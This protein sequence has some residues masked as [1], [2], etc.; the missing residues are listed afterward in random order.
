MCDFC[1]NIKN[2]EHCSDYNGNFIKRWEDGRH[3]L[4]LGNGSSWESKELENI[5]FCPICGRKLEEE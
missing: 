1:E 5:N 3:D 4:F 2:A